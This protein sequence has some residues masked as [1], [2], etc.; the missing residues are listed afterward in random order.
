MRRRSE[1]VPASRSR[2][3]RTARSSS[4]SRPPPGYSE[5]SPSPSRWRPHSSSTANGSSRRDES[6]TLKGCWTR[7]ARSLR[8]SRRPHGWSG[9][10]KPLRPGTR[11]RQSPGGSSGPAFTQRSR[12]PNEEATCRWFSTWGTTLGQQPRP[13]S[14]GEQ[15]LEERSVPLEGDPKVLGRNILAAIPLLL[16]VRPLPGEAF[17]QPLHD[18]GHQ[19]VR[20]LH[21][22]PGLIDEGSL[23]LLPSLLESLPHLVRKQR[24]HGLF[25]DERCFLDRDPL[26]GPVRG[27]RFLGLRLFG[28]GPV[29]FS[30]FNGL[31]IGPRP[32]GSTTCLE[33]RW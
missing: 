29:I 12:T 1:Y 4:S 3:G 9:L 22:R 6:T 21:R 32:G 15:A 18:L 25:T 10:N 24:L 2:G 16:E 13:T 33:V 17:G 19:L 30:L 26:A 28:S 20:R 23:N 7:R 31:V 27:L 8:D 14:S 11:P 5:S